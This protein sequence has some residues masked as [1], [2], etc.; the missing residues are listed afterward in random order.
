MNAREKSVLEAKRFEIITCSSGTDM[1]QAAK[2]MIEED[3]SC[4]IVISEEG[5]IRGIITRTDILRAFCLDPD[6][7]RK[8]VKEYMTKNVVTVKPS[9]I[10]GDVAQLLLDKNIHRV[11]VIQEDQDRNIPVAV[12]SETDLIYHMVKDQADRIIT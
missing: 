8:K 4:L 12:I 6:W 7:N 9:D 2:T 1:L 5:H 11:I 3:I 10:I